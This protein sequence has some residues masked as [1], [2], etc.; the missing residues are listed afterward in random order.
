MLLAPLASAESVA[1]RFVADPA[2]GQAA[3]SL[4]RQ[5]FEACVLRHES[6]TPPADLSPLLHERAGVFVSAILGDAP[7]CC[8]GTLYPIR[9]TL[10]EEIVAA[11]RAAA[12]MDL[13]F[14]PVRPE[15]LSKLRVIVS[16]LRPP[17]PISSP[18]GLNP[19][20]EGLAVRGAKGWG[21][22]L[23][24][25][26]PHHELMERWARI[27]AGADPHEHVDYYRI[28]AYRVVEPEPQAN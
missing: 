2:A 3:L 8:M 6:V 5:T 18:A 9:R 13:R 20:T 17:E 22:V 24:R 12:S 4:A 11:A 25:E 27:R 21:V 16:I 7:R 26:T 14:P 1:E 19:A 15:E 23:P 28:E 10:A